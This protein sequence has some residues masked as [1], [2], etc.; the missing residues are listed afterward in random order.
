MSCAG[1]CTESADAPSRATEPV[2]PG[3]SPAPVGNRGRTTAT[4]GGVEVGIE[5]RQSIEAPVEADLDMPRG[6]Q[7]CGLEDSGVLRD[8]AKAARNGKDAH[9]FA[10]ASTRSVAR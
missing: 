6:E 3:D 2:G 9:R 7:A 4:V 10:R 5:V 1:A 8:R